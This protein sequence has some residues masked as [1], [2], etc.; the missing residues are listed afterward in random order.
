[1]FLRT[2]RK[3]PW[4]TLLCAGTLALG[5][6]I[7]TAVFSVVNGVLLEPLRFREP[8]RIVTLTTKNSDRKTSAVTGGDYTDIRRLNKV[9]DAISVYQ[10]GE[11]GI[12]LHAG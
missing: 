2:V 4:F 9:F 6:G 11:M 5:I 10:G 8:D 1:M 12:Q 7:T 3:S